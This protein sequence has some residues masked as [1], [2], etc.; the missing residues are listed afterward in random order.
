MTTVAKF[1]DEVHKTLCFARFLGVVG[2]SFERV[3]EARLFHIHARSSPERL[4]GRSQSDAL[5]EHK[6]CMFDVCVF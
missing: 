3:D 6:P 1:D 5:G 2:V 4:K